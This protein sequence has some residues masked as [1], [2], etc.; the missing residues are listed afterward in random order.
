MKMRYLGKTGIFEGKLF[1]RGK[2]YEV[3]YF[4]YDADRQWWWY[5]IKGVY[6]PYT[7]EGFQKI[8]RFI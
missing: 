6:I 1:I 8:W 2:V 5:N 4:G 7:E 3:T